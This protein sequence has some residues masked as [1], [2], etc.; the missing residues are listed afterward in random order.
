M[1]TGAQTVACGVQDV[2]TLYASSLVVQ[3]LI[4]IPYAMQATHFRQTPR[5]IALRVLDTLVYAAPLGIITVMLFCGGG[6]MVRLG[7]QGI[8]LVFADVLK[9]AA[10]TSVVS[11][12][13]T[14]TLTGNVVSRDSSLQGVSVAIIIIIASSTKLL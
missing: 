6:S 3:F 11:F 13:K 2:F 8:N 4:L 14:G 9:A 7:K 1:C 12:D 10:Q 5:D